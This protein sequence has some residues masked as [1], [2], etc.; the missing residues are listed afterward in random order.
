[1]IASILIGLL[2][3]NQFSNKMKLL[4]EIVYW[5]FL[6]MGLL[7]TLT[8]IVFIGLFLFL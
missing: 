3:I 8:G 6:T 1:M 2:V 7:G 5:V 4:E